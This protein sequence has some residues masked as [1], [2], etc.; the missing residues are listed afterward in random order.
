MK[1]LV[2]NLRRMLKTDTLRA[3]I[4]IIML[5]AGLSAPAVTDAEME[6]AKAIA[7]KYYVR[8]INNGSG[9]LDN[10]QPKTMAELEKKLA[11]KTDKESLQAFNRAP[12]ATDYSSWDKDR[13]A[14]YWSSTF[15]ANNAAALDSK[16]AANGACKKQIKAAIAA[17]TIAPPSSQKNTETPVETQPATPADGANEAV[18]PE[19]T[20]EE[21]LDRVEAEIE[22]ANALVDNEETTSPIK[23]ENSGTWVYIMVLAILVAIVIFLVVYASKTM[24]GEPRPKKE[25]KEKEREKARDKEEETPEEEQPEI[26]TYTA[27]SYSPVRE[28]RE[29]E[30]ERTRQNIAE[31]S[32]MREKYAE[33]LAQKAEEIRT[34]TRQLAEMEALAASLKDENRQLNAE[35]EQLR[36]YVTASQPAPDASHQERA[37]RHRNESVREVYLGRVNSK[38]I[39]VRADRHAVD[40]QSIYKLS[41]TNGQSGTYAII[42]N[43]LI[44]EQALDDPG[45]WLAGGCFAKDIFDTEGRKGVRTETPGTA[46]FRDGAWRVERKAKIRYI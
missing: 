43:P 18:T 25:D 41:T 38:G 42:N 15:F 12:S 39:F 14:T 33:T 19:E 13:L 8:Y 11:N 23:E 5:G 44:E 3:I 31:D 35:L 7:A 21:E 27:P 30:P 10:W 17:M 24:K 26:E 46:V 34:L 9:Y 37:S 6:E 2:F 45:K 22:E 28:I 4:A 1:F 40:G 29:H 36:K 20:I 32:R 16:A